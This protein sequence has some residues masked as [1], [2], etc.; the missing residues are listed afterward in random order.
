MRIIPR[1]DKRCN[2]HKHKYER[3]QLTSSHIS[4]FTS[5]SFIDAET[6]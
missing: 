6:I 2:S 3:D 1:A 5:E 4:I